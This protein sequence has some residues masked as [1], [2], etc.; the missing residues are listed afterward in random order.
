MAPS[1]GVTTNTPITI[2]GTITDISAGTQQQAVAA[3]FPDGLPCISDASQSQFMEAVY[4]QQAMP[5][6]L[7]GVPIA[8]NVVDANGNYRTIGTTVSNAYGTYSLTWTPDISGDYTVIANFAGTESYYRSE[9]ATA[10]HA[11]DPAATPAPTQIQTST[12]ADTY[13]LPGIIAIIIAIAIVGAVIILVLRK[14][15]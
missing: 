14:R 4:Q 8:I 6:N 3:N 9:A 1:L 7:T 10:F 11:S 13:L 12:A 15:P 5:T 2:K